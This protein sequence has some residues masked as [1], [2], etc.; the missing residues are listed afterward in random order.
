MIALKDGF[1]PQKVTTSGY[2]MWLEVKNIISVA[3]SY[4]NVVMY[5]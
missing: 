2:I 4:D 5:C 3:I 1:T